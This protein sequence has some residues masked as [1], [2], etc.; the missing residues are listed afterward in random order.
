MPPAT[1]AVTPEKA[2]GETVAVIQK[3]EPKVESSDRPAQTAVIAAP[4]PAEAS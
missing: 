2:A 3:P 4:Q 1:A